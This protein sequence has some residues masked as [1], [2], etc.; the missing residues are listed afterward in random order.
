MLKL[1]LTGQPVLVFTWVSRWV[2][3]S[4][5]VFVASLLLSKPCAHVT[6][7]RSRNITAAYLEKCQML[8]SCEQEGVKQQEMKEA[9]SGQMQGGSK[10]CKAGRNSSPLCQ[11]KESGRWSSCNSHNA[12]QHV[13]GTTVL[14][15]TGWRITIF[16]HYWTKT[17]PTWARLFQGR[18][19]GLALEITVNE[20]LQKVQI[21][22][23][24]EIYYLTRISLYDNTFV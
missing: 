16:L 4:K 2:K 1:S 20:W 24:V 22:L 23:R 8:F 7:R 6:G 12:R 14:F 19:F 3:E 18:A 5:S 13:Q 15:S 17:K 11:K 21:T 10:L 9:L